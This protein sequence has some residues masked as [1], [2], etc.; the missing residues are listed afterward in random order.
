MSF[1]ES[2]N[3][4]SNLF[5][6]SLFF[7]SGIVWA[8]SNGIWHDAQ[9]FI[10][11]TLGSDEQIDTNN[12]TFTNF[13]FINNNLSV[14]GTVESKY[15]LQDNH[16]ANKAYFDAEFSSLVPSILDCNK[17]GMI[18]NGS[19]CI[20]VNG[21]DVVP[22]IFDFPLVTNS[23][24][25]VWVNSSEV[26][27]SGFGAN[28]YFELLNNNS[29]V[30][31]IKNGVNTGLTKVGVNEG[32]KIK[33]RILAKGDYSMVSSVDVKLGTYQTFWS[34]TNKPLLPTYY[35][36]P[37]TYTYTVPRTSITSITVEVQGA[38]GGSSK[39]CNNGGGKCWVCAGGAG[40]GG[41]SKSVLSVNPGDTYTVTVGNRLLETRNSVAG[42]KGET[43]SFSSNGN[44]LIYAT[45]GTGGGCN[46]GG[47]GGMG[48]LG[49]ILNIKGGNGGAGA[50]GG[51]GIYA[52]GSAGQP[53]HGYT[54]ANIKNLGRGGR[55]VN[56]PV[57]GLEENGFVIISYN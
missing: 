56:G 7:V 44:I 6:I 41:Y 2:F 31:I 57:F 28:M 9:D 5:L 35:L 46:G 20:Y 37:G 22:N 49:N 36:T 55:S 38:G 51:K 50:A 52:I 27:L 47:G 54:Q 53:K 4:Y 13:V 39:A 21:S 45:G 29:P 11:G 1:K 40:A 24:F 12:F 8:D 25:N 18:Y 19:S 23:E 42:T 10:G 43:S 30:S 16:S 14:N 17:N 32:D 3:F 48:Y 34:V 15:P 33:I 26:V